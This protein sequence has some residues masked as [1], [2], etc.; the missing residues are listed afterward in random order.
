MLVRRAAIEEVGLLDD[1]YFL[2]SEEVDWCWRMRR[3][4][5]AIWQVPAAHVLHVG[6][7][8]SQ[9]VRVRSFIELHRSR[10]R[11]FS[12]ALFGKTLC[13]PTVLLYKLEWSMQRCEPGGSTPD[14]SLRWENCGRGCS[15]MVGLFNY[16]TPTFTFVQ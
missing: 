9:Q 1:G 6:G 15:H 2:Y 16:S 8:S 13:T 12:A 5:W 10:L 7:A 4:G 14:A 11:F 3:A